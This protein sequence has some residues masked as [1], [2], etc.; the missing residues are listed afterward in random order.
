MGC[1]EETGPQENTIW[2]ESVSTFVTR[3]RGPL[4]SMIFPGTI[5][6]RYFAASYGREASAIFGIIAIGFMIS[7]LAFAPPAFETV[8]DETNPEDIRLELRTTGEVVQTTPSYTE[9]ETVQDLPVYVERA[10]PVISLDSVLAA[11]EGTEATVEPQVVYQAY[12]RGTDSA[13]WVKEDSLGREE[14]TVSEDEL[15]YTVPLNATRTR[16]ELAAHSEAFGPEI[17]VT[18]TVKTVVTYDT[19][20]YADQ[21]SVS[22]PLEY[23]SKAYFISTDRI[24]VTETTEVEQTVVNPETTLSIAG[25]PITTHTVFFSIGGLLSALVGGALFI[26]SNRL[27]PREVAEELHQMRYMEWISPVETLRFGSWESSF[28][29]HSIES[30]IDIAIDTDERVLY[31]EDK[32]LY[33]F[34]SGD[35]LYYYTKSDMSPEV[36]EWLVF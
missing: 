13:F 12:E 17:L 14:A 24:E 3:N 6:I 5:R 25:V 26:S 33:F 29:T 34:G 21:V 28:E 16:Q 10:V 20:V 36:R 15:T 7:G 18:A 1:E 9:G 27:N 30:L 32:G 23:S 4:Y 8:V 19:G 31:D 2:S 22:S 35:T 11:P